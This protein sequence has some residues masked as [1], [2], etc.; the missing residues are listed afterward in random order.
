MGRRGRRRSRLS[1][2]PATVGTISRLASRTRRRHRSFP[3]VVHRTA[4]TSAFRR[5]SRF[6]HSEPVPGRCGRYRP[7]TPRGLSV[8]SERDRHRVRRTTSPVVRADGGCCLAGSRCCAVDTRP[9]TAERFRGVPMERSGPRERL[10]IDSIGGDDRQVIRHGFAF[11]RNF[12]HGL[13]TGRDRRR[14]Q[15]YSEGSS[16]PTGRFPTRRFAPAPD[17][18]RGRCERRRYPRSVP[19]TSHRMNVTGTGE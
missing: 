12:I 9:G 15:G 7:P 2:A 19:D 1:V 5:R 17:S 18:S 3:R 10:L 6:G 4:A 14:G 8:R 11:G 16:S 13:P